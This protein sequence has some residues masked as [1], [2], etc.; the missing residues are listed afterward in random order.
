MDYGV[1]FPCYYWCA[2]VVGVPAFVGIFQDAK[3]E[4]A[5]IAVRQ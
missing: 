1:T 5:K 3:E 4:A 2:A